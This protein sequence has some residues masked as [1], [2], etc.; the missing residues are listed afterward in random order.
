MVSMRKNASLLLLLC[1]LL[2]PLRAEAEDRL[3]NLCHS[4]A[5]FRDAS[6]EHPNLSSMF[7]ALEE[8]CREDGGETLPEIDPPFPIGLPHMGSSRMIPYCPSGTGPF[9]ITCQNAV[10]LGCVWY[11]LEHGEMKLHPQE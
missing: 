10:P 5:V 9:G 11:C 3:E 6:F 8:F 1:F 4:I 7:Y 2:L